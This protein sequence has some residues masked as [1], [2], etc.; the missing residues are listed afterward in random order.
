MNKRIFTII[1]LLITVVTLHAQEFETATEAV[2]NMKVGWNLGNTFDSHKIGVTG[3]TETETLRGQAVTTPELMEMMKMAGF[4]AIRVPVTWY[5][6]LDTSG[7]IDPAWM[8]RIQEV[9]DYVINQGMYCIINVHHDTGHKKNENDGNKGWLRAKLENY[10]KNKATFEKIW[11]QIANKFKNYNHLLLFEGYNEML[12]TLGSFN[13]ASYETDKRINIT[14]KQGD[15]VAQIPYDADVA[16][17]AYDAVNAYA[18]SFVE[19][20]RAS[21]GNNAHRNLIVSTYA[22]AD[23]RSQGTYNKEPFVK[24]QKPEDSNHI[25]FEIHTYPPIVDDTLRSMEYIARQIDYMVSNIDTF[26]VQRYNAPVIIGEWGTSNVDAGSGKTDYD[27]HREHMFNFVDYFVQK[28]KENDIATFYWM[29][30]SDKTNRSLPV[31]NQADLAEKILKAYYGEDYEPNL[32][33]Q[34][35]YHKE[36]QVNFAK[37]YAEINLAE[38]ANGLETNY[39]AIRLVLAEAPASNK[40]LRIRAKKPD[41]TYGDYNYVRSTDEILN[42]STVSQSPIN[43][44]NLKWRSDGSL[45]INIKHVYLIKHDGSTVEVVPKTISGGNSTIQATTNSIPNYI[46]AKISDLKYST[47][48]YGNKNLVVPPYV[49][50]TAYSVNGKKLQVVKTYE[51]KDVIPAG[52]GVVLTS[53]NGNTYKFS[54]SDEIGEPAT[55]NMLRG[56]DEAQTTTG[57]DR[58]YMLSLNADSYPSSVGFYYAKANGAAFTNGAHKAYLALSAAQAKAFSYPFNETDGIETITNEHHKTTNGIWYTI[59]GKRLSGQPTRK[60]VYIVDGK[61]M[62]IK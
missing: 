34:N 36:Y 42:F 25:A 4:N 45:T 18:K 22:A 24:M 13:Y 61:K 49:T 47:L 55:G 7:N 20:V 44:I 54:I 53:E 40:E 51:S 19:T 52:T 26:F 29:G 60:G 1:C 59:D 8:N 39:K 62:I 21:G 10:T 58:Y 41:D 2:K 17:S 16:Q 48:Y 35:D 14:N 37:Q 43:K 57:G 31:F 33:S 15:V 5:P 11:Q 12:D 50:A 32:I 27:L 23:A 56:S 46:K 9:V 28:M 3:V 30:L 38:D 6:H